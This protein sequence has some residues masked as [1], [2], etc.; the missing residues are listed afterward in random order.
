MRL[1]LL[2]RFDSPPF[3]RWL[4]ACFLG[5]MAVIVLLSAGVGSKWEKSLGVID[6]ILIVHVLFNVNGNRFE[7]N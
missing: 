3:Q 7:I 4:L 6:W 2:G 5:E 1:L